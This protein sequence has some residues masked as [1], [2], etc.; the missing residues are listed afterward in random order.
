M[1]NDLLKIG[2]AYAL[3]LGVLLFGISRVNAQDR[4]VTFANGWLTAERLDVAGYCVVVIYNTQ[5]PG[6]APTAVACR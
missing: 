5:R 4:P 1:K 3:A 2:L 6:D